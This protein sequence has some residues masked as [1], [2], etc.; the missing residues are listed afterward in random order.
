MR[1]RGGL[2]LIVVGCL[3][4]A[5]G[6]A[7]ATTLTIGFEATPPR[8]PGLGAAY[9][10]PNPGFSVGDAVFSGGSYAGFVVSS[11]TV[12]GTTGY[13]YDELPSSAAEVSAES[14]GGAGGGA[15]G[16]SRFAVAYGGGSLIDL[17]PGFRPAAVSLTNTATA[18]GAIRNG[19]YYA[20]AFGPGDWFRVRFAGRTGVGGTGDPV[21]TPVDF[22]LA[23][24]RGGG[25]LAVD[26]WTPVD[27]TPLGEAASI[28]LSF[29]STDNDPTWGMNTPAYVALD[30]LVVVAEPEPAA[31]VSLAIGL[32]GAVLVVRGRR[33]RTA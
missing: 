13:I 31:V 5:A 32:A 2:L 1:R 20:R 3:V 9:W 11:S 33:G 24:Y 16:S 17:P 4:A 21:G 28:V 25:S 29:A 27:L 6:P 12:T 22:Y 14:N 8:D 10:D 15:G 23:D 30:D 7:A 26:A 18:Y 19:L